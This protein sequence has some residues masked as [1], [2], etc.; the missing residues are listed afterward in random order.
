MIFHFFHSLV[1]SLTLF[2]AAV[3]SAAALF[4]M[5]LIAFSD[6]SIIAAMF[7][8]YA[9]LFFIFASFS[10]RRL[11]RWRHRH[12]AFI[13]HF[14]SVFASSSFDFAD[15]PSLHFRHFIFAAA[16]FRPLFLSRFSRRLPIS[17][18]L[19]HASFHFLHTLSYRH[20]RLR[21]L[22]S[23]DFQLPLADIA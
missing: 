15:T 6:I 4:S 9:C 11:F 21:R 2:A 17:M 18:T 12:A 22:F 23:S 20:F 7:A 14:L 8:F 13:L 1:I 10:R 5:P 16:H 19:F 3:G